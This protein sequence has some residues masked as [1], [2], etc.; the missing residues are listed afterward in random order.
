MSAP[1]SVQAAT[2][3]A[4]EAGPL[5]PKPSTSPASSRELRARRRD[6]GFIEPSIAAA[7]EQHPTRHGIRWPCR[8]SARA[9]SEVI[10]ASEKM[11]ANQAK[12]RPHLLLQA[13]IDSLKVFAFNVSGNA[14]LLER[15]D[16]TR[17][18]RLAE[19]NQRM[20]NHAWHGVIVSDL[21]RDERDNVIR[22][23]MFLK[24]KFSASGEYDKLKARLVFGGEQDKKLYEDICLSSPTASTSSVLAVAAIAAC[25]GRLVTVMD[26][27]G[28]FLSAYITS[29][30]IKVH[31]RLNRVLTDI[32][33]QIDPSRLDLLNALPSYCSTKPST[34]VLKPLHCGTRI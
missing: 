11:N 7:P 1:A 32:L 10:L 30:C 19:L 25:E 3:E 20:E 26:I 16:E 21:T 6:A 13:G 14:A 15:G 33:V 23:S 8:L 4:A 24:E 34:D 9:T 18:V 2:A 17:P 28:A 27:G 31:M 29:T 12:I 22:C 5:A